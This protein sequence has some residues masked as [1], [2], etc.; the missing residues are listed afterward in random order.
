MVKMTD[1]KTIKKV[2][3]KWGRC[4]IVSFTPDECKIWGIKEG[5]IINLEDMVVEN[6]IKQ[7]K[8]VKVTHQ[9]QRLRK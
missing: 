5:T 6:V 8:N 4:F 2:V 7:N 3:K 9:K 1:K